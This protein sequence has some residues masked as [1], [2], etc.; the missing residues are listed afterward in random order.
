[1]EELSGRRVNGMDEYGHA[2]QS[3]ADSANWKA[4]GQEC[5]DS[6]FYMFVSRNK[7]GHKSG[8]KLMRQ[9][10]FNSRLI[11]SFD[12]GK[13]WIRPE[14]ENYATP[15]WAGSQFSSPFFVHY[16][17]NG[18]NET[19]D[20]AHKFVYAISNNGFWN[21]GDNYIIGR[22][23]HSKL[24][25]LNAK[26]WSYYNG[27]DGNKDKNW[28][29]EITKAKHILDLPAKCGQMG[30]T[31]IPS[32]KKYVMIAWYITDTLKSWFNPKEFRYDFYQADHPWGNWT[33]VN[34]FSDNFMEGKHWYGPSIITKFQEKTDDGVKVYLVTSGCGP[35]KDEPNSMYKMWD[36]PLYLKT[37]K[38]SPSEMINDDNS[39]II[40]SS[41]WRDN[42]NK[43]PGDYHMDFHKSKN[44]NDS[45]SYTFTGTAIEVICPKKEMYGTIAIYLDGHLQKSIDLSILNLPRLAQVVVYQSK[46]MHTGKHTIKL[47]NTSDKEIGFDAFRVYK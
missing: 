44:M 34:S 7:Y 22:V 23:P 20:N 13:T 16:G 28:I 35:F 5:I 45:L 27:G 11:K 38:S 21:G 24:N 2:G 12:K 17:K 37:R 25:L 9:T 3:N 30:A 14:S 40:Y 33:F 39:E 1:M 15:M 43:K 46:K 18:G 8:D 41:T 32:L 19:K 36:I 31:Y 47:I 42:L 26:D 10:A 6:V 29:P 4:C